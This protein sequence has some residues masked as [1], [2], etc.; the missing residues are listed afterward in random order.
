MWR[1]EM[2]PAWMD[3]LH[4]LMGTRLEESE[5][6]DKVLHCMDRGLPRFLQHFVDLQSR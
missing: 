2:A 3:M 5:E 1:E 4:D 6:D